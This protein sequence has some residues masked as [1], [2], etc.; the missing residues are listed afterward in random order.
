M[1][2]RK[3]KSIAKRRTQAKTKKPKRSRIKSRRS[4]SGVQFV[5]RPP[6]SAVNTPPGFRAVSMSQGMMEYAQPLMDYV[7]KGTLKDPN[8]AFQLS[9]PLWNYDISLV[10]DGFKINKKDVIKQI[11]K[12]LKMNSQ[13]A[14][15][16]FEMMIQRKG[17]LF[18]KEIQPE[19]PMIMFIRQEE[20]YLISKFDYNSLNISEETYIPS[21]EDKALVKFLNQMD[22]YI[23]EGTDYDD[24]EDHFFK[25]EEKCKG[26]F[27]NWLK[28]KG[29]KEL[30]ED[31]VYN[32]EVW[33]NFIYRY[34]HEDTI[35]LKTVTFIKI[36]EFFVDHVL[37]KV[38][39]EPHEYIT[40]P[41]ALKLFYT[42]L[43]EINYLDRPEKVIKFLNRIEPV[44]IKILKARYS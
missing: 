34:V 11:E 38:M 9:M 33:L 6:I 24:W 16:F 19:D 29:V 43:R 40:W 28:F 26:R 13:E 7:E 3:K 36:E 32:V 2:K 12:T 20:H 4:T 31:F 15:E 25:I 30:V 39:V 18:P 42:F 23:T 41:P 22:A 8:D 27:E 10:Q 35:N 21:N 14:I 37:R 1:S 5:E 44:F 17:Y